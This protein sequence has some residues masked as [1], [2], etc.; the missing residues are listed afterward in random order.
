MSHVPDRHSQPPH[1]DG[2][3]SHGGHLNSRTAPGSPE[4]AARER[5]AL[6][7]LLLVLAPLFLATVIG[8]IA[9]W[10]HDVSS[11]LQSDTA[12]WNAPGV[13]IVTGT[14]ESVHEGSC[15]G[16]AGSTGTPSGEV[17]AAAVVR[18]DEGADAGRTTTIQFTAAVTSSGIR[19][20][21]VIRMYK[22][23]VP[24]TG[25]NDSATTATGVYQFYEFERTWP[26]IVIAIVFVAV[27]ALV[28]RR[29]GVAAIVSLVVA[30]IVIAKFMLPA[31][32]VGSP[33]VLVGLVACS[34]IMFVVIYLTHGFST[35]TTT[36]LLGTLFGLLLSAGLGWWATRA[37]HLTGVTSEDDFIITATAP[38][39][40]LSSVIVCAIIVA[41][42]GVLNDVTVTQASSVWE[43]ASSS[44]SRRDLYRRAMRIGRDHIASSVYTIAF[45]TTGAAMS[46]LVLLSIYAMP[47]SDVLRSETFSE[48]IVRTLIGSIGLVLAVPL[49]TA[50]GAVLAWRTMREGSDRE[51][52]PQSDRQR[53]AD[54]RAG[55]APAH[56]VASA[57]PAEPGD[58]AVTD[59]PVVGDPS[60]GRAPRHRMVE[61]DSDAAFRRPTDDRV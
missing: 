47:L 39:L 49:T 3:H 32:L 51:E 12:A 46:T 53:R 40:A 1:S 6:G 10:P 22:S 18:V 13:S 2:G 36:A 15:Q 27:V 16:T 9:L 43:L 52:T 45:A 14:I 37:S 26:L 4:L 29:R 24:Q 7:R 28:A 23:P 5:S 17:C 35:R 19:S 31:L 20:G 44:T 41:G 11:H 58:R 50:I 42:L 34:A 56:P 57:T 33:P 55:S 54:A 30:F 48:E 60:I 38:N 59:L 61:E 25:Q 8:M 21:Q